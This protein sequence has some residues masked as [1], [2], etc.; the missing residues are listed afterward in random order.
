MA[1]R[2]KPFDKPKDPD[3]V[4]DFGFDWSKWLDNTISEIV[5]TSAW[6]ADVGITID[7]S[8]DPTTVVDDN[9][10]VVWLSGGTAG[11]NY[12]VT[13][14]ITTDVGRIDDRSYRIHVKER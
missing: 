8:P 2:D 9:K 6:T 1:N 5:A 12:I 10:T 3:A 4:L 14:R 13:N 11:E 7:A